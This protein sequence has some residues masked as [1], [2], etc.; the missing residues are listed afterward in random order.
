MTIARTDSGALKQAGLQAIVD[1]IQDVLIGYRPL[2][3]A[4]L[5]IGTSSKK[6]LKL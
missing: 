6:R 2:T 1:K 3:S 4:G 5:A